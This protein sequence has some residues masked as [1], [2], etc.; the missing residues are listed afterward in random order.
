MDT[1]LFILLIILLST[2]FLY[3]KIL[4]MFKKTSTTTLK[5]ILKHTISVNE[6]FRKL[7]QYN[8]KILNNGFR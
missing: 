1:I 5:N 6:Y 3:F 4:G 2:G 7:C 8:F